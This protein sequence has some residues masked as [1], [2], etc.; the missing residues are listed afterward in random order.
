MKILIIS[1]VEDAHAQ[2]VMESLREQGAAAE[3]LDLS[4]FP[5]K[6]AL[7]M[8]F[9]GRDRRFVL[10]RPGGGSLDLSTIHAVWWRRPQPYGLAAGGS[11]QA[12][13]FVYS[14]ASTA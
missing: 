3:L 12:R 13:R 5:G 8:E 10:K 14:V 6:L 11:K 1:S 4:E 9:A 2:A 7:T